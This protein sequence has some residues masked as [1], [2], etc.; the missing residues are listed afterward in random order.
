MNTRIMIAGLA[1]MTAVMVVVL[2][3]VTLLTS[4]LPDG[5]ALQ[6]SQASGTVWRGRVALGASQGKRLGTFQVGLSPL[7]L[8]GGEVRLRARDQAA[9]R[10]FTLRAGRDK[11]VEGLGGAISLD[12][13]PLPGRIEARDLSAIFRDGRCLEASGQI[14]FR[15][16]Q[17]VSSGLD[18]NSQPGT[19][20]RSSRVPRIAEERG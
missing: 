14:S 15:A 9:G 6:A 1:G 7:A 3:P 10:A 12:G 20:C 8:L 16:A 11:G 2:A 18:R 17:N 5:G 19:R 13:G 4:R